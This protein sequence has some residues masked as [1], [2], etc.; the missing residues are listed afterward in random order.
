MADINVER[1]GPSIWPW[2]I[3]LLVL[4][5]L[6]WAIAE[7]VDTDEERMAGVQPVEEVR[8]PAAVPAPTPMPPAGEAAEL[9]TLLPLGSDDIGRSVMLDGQVVGQPTNEGFWVAAELNGE[10]HAIFVQTPARTRDGQML[11]M[12]DIQTGQDVQLMGTLQQAPSGQASTWIQQSQLQQEPDFQRWNVHRDLMLSSAPA[13]QQPGM[14][15]GQQPGMQPGQQPGM[16]PGQQPP[17][18]PG[19]TLPTG[20]Y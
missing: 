4:A 14:Q 11:R 8:E 16:Q 5:L 20:T 12:A 7:M 1:K 9:R 18:Q 3:G 19:D 13:G 17:T 10:L 2:I 6:I 15:P